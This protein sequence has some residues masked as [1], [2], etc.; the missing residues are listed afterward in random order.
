[1]HRISIPRVIFP[2]AAS[3]VRSPRYS[4][5]L[6]KVENRKSARAIA[7]EPRHLLHIRP[8]S[9]NRYHSPPCSVVVNVYALTLLNLRLHTESQSSLRARPSRSSRCDPHPARSRVA[10]PRFSLLVAPARYLAALV[11]N[12]VKNAYSQV[13]PPPQAHPPLFHAALILAQIEAENPRLAETP[14]SNFVVVRTTTNRLTS[15]S[16]EPSRRSSS[17]QRVYRTHLPSLPRRQDP[18]PPPS[19]NAHHR[20]ANALC[21]CCSLL[22]RS[23]PSRPSPSPRI[24]SC[25]LPAS[26]RT[27]NPRN[28]RFTST[29]RSQMP[30]RVC[31]SENAHP[32]PHPL[33]APRSCIRPEPCSHASLSSE[34]PRAAHLRGQLQFNFAAPPL[35]GVRESRLPAYCTALPVSP[36]RARAGPRA[37]PPVSAHLHQPRRQLRAP[38]LLLVLHEHVGLAPGLLADAPGPVLQLLV[39]EVLAPQA[40]V[41]P[42]GGRHERRGGLFAGV[43]DAQR[44]AVGAQR[45]RRPRRRTTTR[46]RNSNAD[47]GALGQLAKEALQPRHVL[48][49]V[50]AG[51]G[52]A[53]VRAC[54]P[55][56]DVACAR[57]TS[58]SSPQSCSRLIVR[59]AARRLEHEREA[60]RDTCS[61]QP[62]ARSPS[63]CGRTCC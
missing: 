26:R 53:A 37:S 9:T 29:H 1:M 5:L 11:P 7:A 59:D 30:A 40:Q 2:V 50:S 3:P 56:A 6:T 57:G 18:P 63:A 28:I 27:A 32:P 16:H 55:S 17:H 13:R 45:R 36:R 22:S 23:R 47:A 54:G 38:S 25:P 41:A 19:A 33:L 61:A 49:E 62:R 44:G 10:P 24:I 21:A 31:A 60:A 42:V 52:T 43:G 8:T 51:A 39:A 4:P 58:I 48:L 46:C 20:E 12:E 34:F 15:T 35:A 14:T